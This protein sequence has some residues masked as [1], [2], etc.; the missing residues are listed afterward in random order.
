MPITRDV[1][2]SI[3]F[4]MFLP[5]TTV[6]APTSTKKKPPF[7]LTL[8]ALIPRRSVRLDLVVL[9]VC[10]IALIVAFNPVHDPED[11]GAS[12]GCARSLGSDK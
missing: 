2:I 3:R 10:W 7:E 6:V 5:T 12:R 1:R 9:R 11:L 8:A 4:A